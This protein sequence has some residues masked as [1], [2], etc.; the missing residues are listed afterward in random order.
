[1]ASRP[2]SELLSSPG[3]VRAGVPLVVTS[4]NTIGN[5]PSIPVSD[6][7]FYVNGHLVYDGITNAGVAVNVDPFTLKYNIAT[8]DE[9]IARYL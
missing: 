1:M 4:V 5:L 2:I 6:V 8:T 3:G 7:E 9:V